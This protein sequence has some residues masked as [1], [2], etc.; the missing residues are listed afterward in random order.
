MYIRKVM[1]HEIVVPRW[2]GQIMKIYGLD[3]MYCGRHR[4]IFLK[5]DF[6]VI[7]LPFYVRFLIKYGEYH[8]GEVR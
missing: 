8:D 2:I 3:P 4:F 1:H 7:K 6:K 5:Q